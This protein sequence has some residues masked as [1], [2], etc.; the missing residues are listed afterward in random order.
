MAF[1]RKLW[2]TYKIVSFCLP[3]VVKELKDL[4]G[5]TKFMVTDLIA[6]WKPK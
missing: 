4:T 1:L 5:V 2:K 6:I 3:D